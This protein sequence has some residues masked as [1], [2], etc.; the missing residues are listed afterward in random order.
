MHAQGREPA[1]ALKDPARLAV[2]ARTGLVDTEPDEAFARIVRLVRRSLGT[3]AA[4]VS[5]VSD[6]RDY[7]LATDGLSL[8]GYS[9]TGLPVTESPGQFVVASGAP[10]AVDDVLEIP[11]LSESA[12][13]DALN[14]RSYC[15]VPIEVSGQ[16]I[17]AVCAVANEPRHWTAEDIA[18]LQD[19]SAIAR[20]AVEERLARQAE[21][22]QRSIFFWLMNLLP[23]AV[24][25]CDSKANIAYF[26]EKSAALWNARPEFGTSE[27]A[28]YSQVAQDD[29]AQLPIEAVF[30]TGQPIQNREMTFAEGKTMLVSADLLRDRFDEIMGAVAVLHDVTEM[31]KADH[32][33]DELLSLVS[34][35]LRT[36]LTIINGMAGWLQRQE[37]SLS[38]DDRAAAIDDIVAS[39]RRIERTV[40]NM[41]LLSQFQHERMEPEP[42]HVQQLLN[43]AI[44]LHRRD[45]PGSRV[46]VIVHTPAPI[47]LAIATWARLT[48]VNLLSN[49]EQYGDRTEPHVIEAEIVDTTVVIRICDSGRLLSPAEYEA[50]FE[51]FYR[52]PES[53]DRVPGA[54]LGLTLARRLSEAQGGTLVAGPR[55]DR[56]GTT[57]T[58]TLPAIEAAVVSST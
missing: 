57:L 45:F 16:T 8:N 6:T 30:A 51:P 31:R 33:R 22:E 29:N 13:I 46:T 38:N 44:E 35:E 19:I 34:H 21:G 50:I 40:E 52:R 18:A 17:G 32:L 53:A 11:Q 10:F 47:V 42:V 2:L 15:G 23:V 20:S 4:A 26:N 43:D 58:L 24:Y 14:L 7:F 36:P 54:G 39:G 48:L 49:A 41:L 56:E 28:A 5:L 27:S 25:A 1:E 12:A 3:P 9:S 55:A 37:P